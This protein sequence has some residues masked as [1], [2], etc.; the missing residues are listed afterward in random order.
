[1][2]IDH[3]RDLEEFK[4]LYYSRPMPN[5]Y[6]LDFLLNNP[7]LYCFY[8]INK[9]DLRGFITIQKEFIEE[10]GKTVL[11]LSGISTKKNMANNIKA[12]IKVCSAFNED[13]YSYSE[14]KNAQLVLKKAGFKEI[15][16]NI[17]MRF[18]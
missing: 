7:H 6:E 10:L 12:I 15:E 2:I 13:M 14:L 18:R 11:T 9:G 1:M 3:I 16:K 4:N 5:Q 17:Y 8:G